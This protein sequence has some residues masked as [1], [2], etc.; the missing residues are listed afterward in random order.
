MPTSALQTY[1]F[2]D[3]IKEFTTGSYDESKFSLTLASSVSPLLESI[4][5]DFVQY[6]RRQALSSTCTRKNR[7]F[8]F[9]WRKKNNSL[10]TLIIRHFYDKF[11]VGDYV[12]GQQ[13]A[14]C[15]HDKWIIQNDRGG[16]R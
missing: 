8:Q 14:I 10:Q 4:R 16:F 11:V 13:I 3:Y 7:Q 15:A 1:G 9:M 2:L 5:K 6:A 12:F